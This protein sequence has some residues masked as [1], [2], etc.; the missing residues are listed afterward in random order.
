MWLS[1]HHATIFPCLGLCSHVGEWWAPAAADQ[2]EGQPEQASGHSSLHW[3]VR[4]TWLP[5]PSR[6]GGRLAAREGL[7][8]TVSHITHSRRSRLLTQTLFDKINKRHTCIWVTCYFGK[9]A[10]SIRI[11]TAMMT[12][13]LLGFFRTARFSKIHCFCVAMC[14]WLCFTFHLTGGNSA[15]SRAP[16]KEC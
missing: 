11:L 6:G 12:A 3:D 2:R 16:A 13:L 4:P 9:L 14:Q 15:C 10:I 8:W 7:Q 1:Q 5:L